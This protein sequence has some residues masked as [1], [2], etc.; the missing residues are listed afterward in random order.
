MNI[1]PTR[2][3]Q[4][5]RVAWS[6]ERLIRERAIALGQAI[7]NSTERNYN[8][9]LNSYLEFI[10]L[11]DFPLQPTPDTL[12]FFT[13]FM[14]HHIRPNSIGTYLSGICNQLEPYF[15]RVR[16]FRNSA[17]V[18]R[19]LSGCMR[20]RGGPTHR[21]CALT[22][23][24]IDTIVTVLGDSSDHDD[25]LFIAQVLT[26]FFA[27]H[28]LGEL[29][30]P[31]QVSLCDLRKVIRQSSVRLSTTAYQYLLPGHKADKFFDGNIVVIPRNASRRD[32][33]LAF[34]T[35]LRSRDHHFPFSTA[36]WIRTNGTIPTRSWFISRLRRF[37]DASVGGQS[38]RAGGATS[39]AANGIAPSI[40][41][42]IGR[43]TSESFRIYIRKNPV[44]LQAMLFTRLSQAES[45]YIHD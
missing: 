18:S 19:T 45:S 31:D 2:S 36:L 12:S 38:L 35:Y 24:D 25:L 44:V 15:P 20:L 4:P 28:R 33:W 6:R 32:P 37:F 39:L 26:G 27:L 23:D 9:A 5:L 13:V 43:W 30:Y 10:R 14:C 1:V 34:T 21:K 17:L 29:T 40:I 22:L 8:S 3:K 41:Q 11:H 7:D 16:E 42:D